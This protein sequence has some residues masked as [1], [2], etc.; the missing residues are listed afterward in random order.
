LRASFTSTGCFSVDTPVRPRR[1]CKA[2][3]RRALEF[4]ARRWMS[5]G[6]AWR[7]RRREFFVAAARSSTGEL[8]DDDRPT[9]QREDQQHGDGDLASASRSGW[10][11]SPRWRRTWW[12]S[13]VINGCLNFCFRTGFSRQN[14]RHPA[15]FLHERACLP[16]FLFGSSAPSSDAA[17]GWVDALLA[18]PWLAELAAVPWPKPLCRR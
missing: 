11:T 18:R 8:G 13:V 3:R 15:D 4:L 9:E 16:F 6:R 2:G 12:M 14:D 5:S 1:G 7:R 17:S 10:H